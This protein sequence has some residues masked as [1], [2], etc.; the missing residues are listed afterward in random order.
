[1]RRR[2]LEEDERHKTTVYG[3]DG[4]SCP[5]RRTMVAL[6]VV[7]ELVNSSYMQKV[8]RKKGEM[9][10]KREVIFFDHHLGIM[11][12]VGRGWQMDI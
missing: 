9:R 2:E 3:G 4:R 12:L 7:M 8:V 5:I 6:P 1:M 11:P 10:G